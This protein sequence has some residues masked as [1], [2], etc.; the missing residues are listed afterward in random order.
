MHVSM[1][2]SQRQIIGFGGAG[3][4]SATLLEASQG[5][6]MTLNHNVGVNGGNGIASR[7][8]LRGQDSND[9]QLTSELKNRLL[10]LADLRKMPRPTSL[11]EDVLYSNTE[12]LLF[13]EQGASKTFLILDWALHMAYG[14]PWMRKKVARN[15][16]TLIV[17]GEGSGRL[18]ADRIDAW[19]KH[20]RISDVSRANECIKVTKYPVP[21][22]DGESVC[23]LMSLINTVGE[24]M[25]FDVIVFDTLL[26]NFGPGDENQQR[27]M[28]GFLRVI[29]QIRLGTG[30][31]IILVH[32][33]GHN[34]TRRPQ[35][36]N[37]L[38]RNIDIE[39][40]VDRLASDPTLCCLSGGGE[41]KN[42]H[43]PGLEPMTYR[44][45][46][47]RTG[48]CDVSGN[49]IT[50]CVLVHC[51]E[52]AKF[53]SNRTKTMRVGRNQIKII[54]GL[55]EFWK[56]RGQCPDAPAGAFISDSEFLVVY[57]AAELT[58]QQAQTVKTGF[59]KK[60]WFTKELA[61]FRC[62]GFPDS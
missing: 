27:D 9:L 41:L 35:G 52:E 44:L 36:A 39:L 20:H 16:R 59:I 45:T 54:T 11:I 60:G 3:R 25:A 17:C 26:A 1:L 4:D 38:R 48:N 8:L 7:E 42:R 53:C 31:A 47:A 57:R 5:I 40:R 10:C 19:L 24:S 55:Q 12:L 61:G 58:K 34:H 33:T 23:E 51:K 49:E 14:L 29:R 28:A 62:R 2:I 30:A 37:A 43:G 46:S 6:L 15:G 13:S 56:Q 18:L 32:H 21:V 22:L 50:S